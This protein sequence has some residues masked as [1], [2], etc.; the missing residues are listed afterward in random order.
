MQAEPL[1]FGVQLHAPTQQL[2][3]CSPASVQSAQLSQRNT[4][5]FLDLRLPGL[6]PASTYSTQSTKPTIHPSIYPQLV[7]GLQAVPYMR[8]TAG[9]CKP[10]DY[11]HPLPHPIHPKP[12]SICPQL[13]A[14]L[15]AVPYSVMKPF[16][17]RLD[18]AIMCEMAQMSVFKV[19]CAV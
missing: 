2:A 3:R 14:G 8:P 5:L 13:V 12:P 11:F 10:L 19:G 16:V 18:P 9:P 7:A 15:E 17:E 4:G 6:L 1:C